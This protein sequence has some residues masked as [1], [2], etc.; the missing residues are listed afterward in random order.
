MKQKLCETDYL[1][2]PR[3]DLDKRELIIPCTYETA[4]S[5][6]ES[7]RNFE[8]ADIVGIKHKGSACGTMVVNIKDK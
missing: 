1:L 6:V 7:D 4:R 2:K 8:Y 3:Y 5:I